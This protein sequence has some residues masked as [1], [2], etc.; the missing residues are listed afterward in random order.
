ML[1]LTSHWGYWLPLSL[2]DTFRT[3][4]N[5]IITSNVTENEWVIKDQISY[6]SFSN[7]ARCLS[8]SPQGHSKSGIS[9]SVSIKQIQLEINVLNDSQRNT[10]G[11][12]LE[13]LC[14]RVLDDKRAW[15]RTLPS[16]FV[17]TVWEWLHTRTPPDWP[18]KA[19]LYARTHP[20]YVLA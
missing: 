13:Y 9:E 1:F 4:F 7:L 11:N 12:K 5:V 19:E 18:V 16:R 8:Y 14:L 17:K 10:A 3:K 6:N 15:R 20:D 2:S